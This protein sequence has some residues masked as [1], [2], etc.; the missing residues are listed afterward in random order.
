MVRCHH[1]LAMSVY[2]CFDCDVCFCLDCSKIHNERI[3]DTHHATQPISNNYM[4]KSILDIRDLFTYIRDIKCL[5]DGLL[6]VTHDRHLLLMSVDGK[7]KQIIS[8]KGNAGKISVVNRYN[9]AVLLENG[10]IGLCVVIE[11][12]QQRQKNQYIHNEGISVSLNSPFIC[13]ENQFYVA[14]YT[15]INVTDMSGVFKTYHEIGFTPWDMCYNPHTQ[16]IYCIKK[17]HSHLYCIDTAGNIIFTFAGPNKQYLHSLT[18]ENDV[19]VL[20]LCSKKDDETNRVISVDYNGKLNEVEITNIKMAKL[21][22]LGIDTILNNYFSRSCISF[23]RLTNSVVVG[24]NSTI[25]I[26][27]KKQMCE[28]VTYSRKD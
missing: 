2:K 3:T 26:Y 8:L 21:E 9:V 17:D 1:C 19:H 6:A 10:Q 7:Q 13:T 18:M 22:Q 12:I 27:G 24:V 25:Y 23:H 15:G 4:L 5:H 14:S 28:F 20:L 16:R 11:D